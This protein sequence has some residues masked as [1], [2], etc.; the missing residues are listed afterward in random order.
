MIEEVRVADGKK[1]YDL[2]ASMQK[3]FQPPPD[4]EPLEFE[5]KKPK[6]DFKPRLDD[7]D[8]D[9]TEQNPNNDQTLSK[10]FDVMDLLDG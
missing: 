3:D 8:E 10:N 1:V 6:I 9:P 4:M 5:D 2:L 7:S